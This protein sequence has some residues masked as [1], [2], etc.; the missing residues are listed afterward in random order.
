MTAEDGFLQTSLQ[1][2]A[3]LLRGK[4]LFVARKEEALSLIPEGKS[5]TVELSAR[6]K[7]VVTKSDL[8]MY[9]GVDALGPMFSGWLDELERELMTWSDATAHNPQSKQVIDA[10]RQ[11]R[12]VVGGL[13][14]DHGGK[15]T[16][17]ASFNRGSEAA[18]KFLTALP[19]GP[20]ASDLAGLP[21]AV[22]WVAY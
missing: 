11:T 13:S 19:A 7:E 20:G 8:A 2:K 3:I 10:L 14:L 5:V 17:L 16:L 15:I 12:R 21:A 1:V 18:M 6:Q 4:H 9:V 22:P